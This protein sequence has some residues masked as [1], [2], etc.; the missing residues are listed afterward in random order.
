MNESDIK[1]IRK[2]LKLTQKQFAEK[3]GVAF[4]TVNRWERNHFRPS[5]LALKEIGELLKEIKK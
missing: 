4:S 2:K 3:I 1:K 5:K